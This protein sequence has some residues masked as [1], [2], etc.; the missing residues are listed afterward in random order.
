MNGMEVVISSKQPTHKSRSV[1][2]SSLLMQELNQIY[3]T[4]TAPVINQ[5]SIW[6][7]DKNV[8]PAV[9]SIAAI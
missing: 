5:T 1:A 8:C 9:I 2:L 3:K 7:L 6:V 4:S